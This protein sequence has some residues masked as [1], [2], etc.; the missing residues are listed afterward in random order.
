MSAAVSKRQK[1]NDPP[2]RVLPSSLVCAFSSGTGERTA[3]LDLPTTSSTKQLEALLNKLLGNM[4]SIPYAFYLN[5][6]EIAD[7]LEEAV[8]LATELS[9][10]SVLDIAYQPLSV[11]RVRPVTRCSETMP[12]HTDAVLHVSYSNDGRRLAR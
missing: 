6:I 8:K 2:E 3:N 4:E 7:S 9:L 11:F 12:G 1:K 5:D 10:E